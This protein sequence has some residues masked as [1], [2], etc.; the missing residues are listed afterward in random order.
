MNF[1][2][3]K[4]YKEDA[5]NPKGDF[6]GYEYMYPNFPVVRSQLQK[7]GIRLAKFLEGIFKKKNHWG[8]SSVRGI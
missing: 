7:G 4:K 3:Y 1:E 8:D 5:V 6:L 2:G